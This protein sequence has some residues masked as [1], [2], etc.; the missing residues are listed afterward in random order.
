VVGGRAAIFTRGRRCD[1]SIAGC[2]ATADA[3][4]NVTQPTRTAAWVA[5]P[6][7]IT[8]NV[9]FARATPAGVTLP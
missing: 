1:A 2:G 8:G 7:H 6:V 4:S 5:S 9:T 3:P